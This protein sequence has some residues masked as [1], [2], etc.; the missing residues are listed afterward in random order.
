MSTIQL[1]W[2]IVIL[3]RLHCIVIS[4]RTHCGTRWV[5]CDDKQVVSVCNVANVPC[6]RHSGAHQRADPHRRSPHRAARPFAILGGDGPNAESELRS[7]RSLPQ[8]S[9]NL[10]S[11]LEVVKLG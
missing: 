1:L 7:S 9:K 3:A 2:A 10:H 6:G 11:A 4:R 8:P 5:W